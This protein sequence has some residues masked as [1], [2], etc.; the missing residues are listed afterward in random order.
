MAGLQELWVGQRG[1]LAS[2]PVKNARP[3]RNATVSQRGWQRTASPHGCL[4]LLQRG[5]VCAD[6]CSAFPRCL[7]VQTC[8]L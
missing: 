5:A 8:M 2:P 6:A 3:R 7:T 1:A 4:A